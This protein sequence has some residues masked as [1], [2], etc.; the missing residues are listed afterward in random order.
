MLGHIPGHEAAPI[1]HDQWAVPTLSE[2][3]ALIRS[4]QAPV[5]PAPGPIVLGTVMAE[6]HCES[7][8]HL[9][10]AIAALFVSS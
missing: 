10:L 7:S 9:R 5:L 8:S 2:I 6:P 1:F 3:I 4:W